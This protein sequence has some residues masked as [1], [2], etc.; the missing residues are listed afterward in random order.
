MGL[1][2]AFDVESRL[3]Y[4]FWR[5]YAR[6][7]FLALALLWVIAVVLA[8]FARARAGRPNSIAR[9]G[10]PSLIRAAVVLPL[11]CAFAGFVFGLELGLGF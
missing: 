5:S 8:I 4:I 6:E 11:A 7:A 10:S 3:H 2:D 9:Y 1:D